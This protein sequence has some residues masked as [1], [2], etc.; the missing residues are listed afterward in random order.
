MISRRSFFKRLLAGV[1]V[2]TILPPAE[3]YQR[4]WTALRP[5]V[6]PPSSISC[7][8]FAQL[9]LD[10]VPRFDE[11]IMEQVRPADDWIGHVETGAVP[12]DM[13]AEF[14]EQRLFKTFERNGNSLIWKPP[15]F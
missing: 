2:F 1:G 13:T 6:L 10:Q 11:L 3:T 14:R 5:A 9:L 15:G 7:D 8:V 4:I 12:H